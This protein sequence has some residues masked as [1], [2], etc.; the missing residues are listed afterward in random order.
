MDYTKL[1]VYSEAI[2]LADLLVRTAVKTPKS[3]ALVVDDEETTYEDLLAGAFEVARALRGIGVERGDNVGILLPNSRQFIEIAFGI[4]LLGAVVVPLN[5]RF[6]SSELAYVIDHAQLRVVF[7]SDLLGERAS[8]RK[9]LCESF[10]SLASAPSDGDLDLPEAPNLKRVVT[11]TGEAGPGIQ[12]L[13]S[14]IAAADGVDPHEIDEMRRR[15]SVRDTALILYTSGTTAHPKG[16]MI[17]HEGIS[18]GSQGRFRENVPI[19][20]DRNVFWCPGPMF[21]IACIQVVLGAIGVGGTF[22]TSLYFDAERSIEQ[23]ARTRV[24]S[25]WPWFQAVMNGLL[26]AKNFDADHFRDVNAISLIGAEAF[27][28]SVQELFPNAVQITGAGMTE[29]S[30]YYAMSRLHDTDDVR[31]TTA[32]YPVSGVEIRIVDPETGIDLPRG[33]PGELLARGY[34]VM[35]GYFRDEEKTAA[36]IDA[37][38]WLHTADLYTQDANGHLTFKGRIKDM[39]KVGGENVPA[40]EVEAFLCTHPDVRIAEV[41]AKHDERL[42]EVPVAFV[43]LRPGAATTPEQLIDFCKGRIASYK[44]PRAVY[45]KAPDEWPMSATKV[46]KNVLREEVARIARRELAGRQ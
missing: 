14:F 41:V 24:T 11:V 32:G 28:R 31:A 18:R 9:I 23:I 44:V 4:A 43:E 20:D 16:C 10:P 27:L 34:L 45:F 17:T 36:T 3:V 40:I 13:A 42:D 7:I 30:G 12:D 1:A 15:V 2:P 29:L 21:H 39:L 5:A 19:R 25:L 6:K 38:G 22:V 33:M 26:T 35:K 37:D 46:N 8:F